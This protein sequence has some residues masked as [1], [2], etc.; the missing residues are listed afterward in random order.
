MPLLS[1]YFTIQQ[2]QERYSTMG[3]TINT[4]NAEYFTAKVVKLTDIVKLLKNKRMQ[5]KAR[6]RPEHIQFQS[7]SSD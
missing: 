3:Q 7:A 4:I 6:L 5:S 1:L 2:S